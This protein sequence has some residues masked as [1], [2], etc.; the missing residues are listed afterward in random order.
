[1]RPNNRTRAGGPKK[2]P[3]TRDEQG[4][5]SREKLPLHT[6]T[7]MKSEMKMSSIDP[8]NVYTPTSVA[9]NYVKNEFHT[10]HKIHFVFH[11]A[12]VLQCFF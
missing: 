6:R 1:M 8:H 4:R 11:L 7:V 9:H 3:S 5:V 2:G 10:Y 12:L